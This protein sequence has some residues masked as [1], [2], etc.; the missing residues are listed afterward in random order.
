MS[1]C[2]DRYL[3]LAGNGVKL[4]AA[5]TPFINEDQSTSPQGAPCESGPFCECPW[6]KNTFPANVHQQA[7]D[8]SGDSNKR[9]SRGKAMANICHNATHQSN[10]GKQYNLSELIEME[11]DRAENSAYHAAPAQDCK[12]PVSYTHLTLPTIL[13]V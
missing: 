9:W 2:V 10:D 3:E 1:S 13:R 4:K 8:V 12:G 6:C 7:K 11:H 5:L